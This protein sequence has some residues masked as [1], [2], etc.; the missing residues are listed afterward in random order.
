MRLLDFDSNLSKNLLNHNDDC[1]SFFRKLR[2]YIR[3][4]QLAILIHQSKLVLK[5]DSYRTELLLDD[6][7]KDIRLRKYKMPGNYSDYY[8]DIEPRIIGSGSNGRIFKA[9]RKSDG[10]AVAVKIVLNLPRGVENEVFFLQRCQHPKYTI[11]YF[12]SY[13]IEGHAIAVIVTSLE[14]R[15]WNPSKRCSRSI[16]RTNLYDL[17]AF[18]YT[19]QLDESDLMHVV[20]SLF[21]II[22]FMHYRVKVVHGDI[23]PSNFLI[24]QKLNI[25]L[26]DMSTCRD[27]S[28]S[29][30]LDRF[31]GSRYY[32]SDEAIQKDCF[33]GVDN[34]LWALG[35]IVYECCFGIQQKPEWHDNVVMFHQPFAAKLSNR[36]QTLLKECIRILLHKDPSFD[37]Q[38]SFKSKCTRSKPSIMTTKRSWTQYCLSKYF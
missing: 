27:I 17:E 32:A 26:I 16:R 1:H 13:I 24:D 19:N 25:K 29:Q 20:E 23:K 8:S 10:M 4:K 38:A 12:H 11:R 6:I 15:D 22:Y 21:K 33:N 37:K 36:N 31:R 35:M 14:G 5:M 30:T 7:I 18:L 3:A 2:I 9:T 34:D 28:K